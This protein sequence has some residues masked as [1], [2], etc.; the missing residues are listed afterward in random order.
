MSLMI[1]SVITVVNDVVRRQW[2]A[3]SSSVNVARPQP[4]ARRLFVRRQ[5]MSRPAACPS[6][7]PSTLSS[8]RRLYIVVRRQKERTSLFVLQ[9]DN[10]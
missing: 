4:C 8:A 9:A 2:T 6:V 7:R 5:S 1:I 3:R 10:V